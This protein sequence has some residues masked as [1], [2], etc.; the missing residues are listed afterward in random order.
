MARSKV[1][2]L[3]LCR[4]LGGRFWMIRNRLHLRLIDRGGRAGVGEGRAGWDDPLLRS[5]RACVAGA[6]SRCGWHRCSACASPPVDVGLDVDS[7][8]SSQILTLLPSD[9]QLP[10]TTSLASGSCCSLAATSSSMALQVLSTRHGFLALGY[11]HSFSLLACGGGGGGG[12]G[13]FT[14]T[15]LEAE[16]FKPRESV[17]VALTVI[18]PGEAPV[19]LRSRSFRC[20]TIL[21]ALALHPPT[22]TGTLSGLVQVQV[23]VAGPFRPQ[24]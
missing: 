13:L 15:V 3:L 24:P 21:P 2:H 8:L 11:S 10:T 23:M 4:L 17:Q 12:G 1:F 22:V 16:A 20:R 6:A 18:G 9:R 14:V 7:T 5:R 19:V